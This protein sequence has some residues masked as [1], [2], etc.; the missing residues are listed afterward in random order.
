MSGDP[1][2]STYIGQILCIKGHNVRSSKS[3]HLCVFYPLPLKKVFPIPSSFFPR[4]HNLHSVVIDRSSD[5]LRV[6]LDELELSEEVSDV[7]AL[8]EMYLISK[9]A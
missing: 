9:A 6:G 5:T 2:H 1:F 7:V 4:Q 3:T 8:L